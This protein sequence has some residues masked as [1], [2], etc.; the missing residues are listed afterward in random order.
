MKTQLDKDMETVKLKIPNMISTHCQV[1][2]SNIVGKLKGAQIKHIRPG[3]A[4]VAIDASQTSKT[5]VIEAI[6]KAG[7]RIENKITFVEYI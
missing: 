5:Q 2:V 4:E 1:T 3:E 6:E 7:Y